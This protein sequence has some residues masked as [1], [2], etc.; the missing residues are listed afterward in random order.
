MDLELEFG[1]DPAL[2][3]EGVWFRM[4]GGQLMPLRG[5]VAKLEGDFAEFKLSFGDSKA[6][7]RALRT[8]QM[9]RRQDLSEGAGQKYDQAV[10]DIACGV[11]ADAVI[12]DWRN[13][14][15]NKKPLEYSRNN[16]F[17]LVRKYERLRRAIDA[18]SSAA[19]AYRPEEDAE[20]LG[21]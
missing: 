5:E 18:A 14:E 17:Q 11:L 15:E 4:V 10:I 21:N 2:A 9:A 3:E 6:A 19:S 1:T 12:R 20:A 7:N 16:A 8:H 13:I